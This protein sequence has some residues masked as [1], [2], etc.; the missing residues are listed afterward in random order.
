MTSAA[1]PSHRRY[2]SEAELSFGETSRAQ[3]LIESLIRHGLR[4]RAASSG[5]SSSCAQPDRL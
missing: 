5:A 3:P 2:W 1:T 4:E